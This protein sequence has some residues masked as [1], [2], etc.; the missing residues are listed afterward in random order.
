TA[1]E[2]QEL[3]HQLLQ[4]QSFH[5]E[6]TQRKTELE[7]LR[8]RRDAIQKA[9]EDAATE[10]ASEKT[11]SQNQKESLEAKKDKYQSEVYQKLV[12]KREEYRKMFELLVHAQ[13][14]AR[15]KIG[16]AKVQQ[17]PPQIPTYSEVPVE[18]GAVFATNFNDAFAEFDR[19]GASQQFDADFGANGEDPFA[20]AELSKV[21]AQPQ[22]HPAEPTHN[23]PAVDQSSFNTHDT[24][25]C[26]ALFAFE[27]RSED[28]LSFEPGDVII[29]F[30]SHM[31]EPG[32]KAGQL[33][34]KVGWFPEAFVETIAAVPQ[35]TSSEPPIQNVP[36]NMTPSSSVDEIQ[37]RAARKAEIAKAMGAG[38]QQVGAQ[39][40]QSAPV[41]SQCVA[42]FQWRA[43]NEED[44]SFAKGDVI[45]VL[46]K[47]EMKWKGR[48]PA[49]ETGWFPK[50]YVKEV[51]TSPQATK[52]AAQPANGPAAGAPSAQYDVVPA[53]LTVMSSGGDDVYTAVYDFE[54]AESTDLALRVGDTIVVLE[55]NDEWWKGRC[56]GKEGIF[57]SNYVEKAS[58]APPPPVLCDAK[59]LVDFT[60][61][62]GNQLAIK[63]G[64]IVKVREKSTAGWWEGEV[65]R[66]GKAFAGWFPGE[67]VKVVENSSPTKSAH[68]R[69][70]ALFDYDASQSDE[71]SFKTGDVIIVTDRSEAEWWTGHKAT[72][73]AKSGL[74]PSNYVEVL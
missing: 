47:Q 66:D 72:E 28:E 7:S 27:A 59:V 35:N 31:A 46:E 21:N 16:E 60:A 17:P 70:T 25:K 69:A 10:L 36:P 42:Q 29:V 38:E 8:R 22:V 37:L 65:I 12:M 64:E 71:L 1:I 33:R 67:Y 19:Q 24:Y 32:W 26:R 4:K 56:N 23:R 18:N 11:K 53:D 55:K 57:P 49:G 48:N 63:V 54:A 40:A 58:P 52:P 73:P 51:G 30:Q 5:K 50:S 74:F 45:E 14:Q 44:L 3:G 9:I 41:I 43:R 68:P 20:S 34:E 13:T 2:S 39:A 62:A 15:S 61:S 6:S